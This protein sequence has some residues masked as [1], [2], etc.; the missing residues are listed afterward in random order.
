MPIV[1]NSKIPTSSVASR[2][3]AWR[4]FPSYGNVPYSH[5]FQVTNQPV[6]LVGAGIPAPYPVILQSS[7]DGGASWNDVVINGSTAQLTYRNTLLLVKV[8]G[9][10]RLRTQASAPQ[11]TVTGYPFTMTHEPDI[12]LVNLFPLGPTGPTGDPG[13]TGPTGPA[14]LRGLQGV[15]GP[16]GATG[17]SGPTGATGGGS[18]GTTGPTGPTGSS[19]FGTYRSTGATG[20]LA[21]DDDIVFITAGDITLTLPSANTL[22]AGNTPK[23][24]VVMGLGLSDI[25]IAVQTGDYLEGVLNGTLPQS[26]LQA[27]T[28]VSNG[29]GWWIS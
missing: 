7:M 4:F 9:N 25:T 13:P 29:L 26:T 17:P 6:A 24:T 5:A 18:T 11:P 1:T 19:N 22:G 3:G 2:V 28:Y 10:Y 12:P 14:G 23:I 27:A 16:R 15:T 8:A 20:I 21:G